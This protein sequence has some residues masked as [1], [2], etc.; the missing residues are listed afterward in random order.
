MFPQNEFGLFDMHGNVAEW[1]SDFY[2]P[3]YYA[4][5]PKV[6]PTGPYFGLY[7]I[8]RG[9][10]FR[11]DSAEVRSVDRSGLR[12]IGIDEFLGFRVVAELKLSERMPNS[13]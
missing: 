10:C 12:Q 11:S 2:S 4:H 13:E 9:G 5:S 1:C 7:R 8:W 6:N 3:D